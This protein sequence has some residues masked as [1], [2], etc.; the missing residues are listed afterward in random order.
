MLDG[1]EAKDFS[2]LTV[3]IIILSQ[4]LR[5]RALPS[6]ISRNTTTIKSLPQL[7][8]MHLKDVTILNMYML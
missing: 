3:G 7:E 8:K 1:M 4:V 5:I 2:I 6:C